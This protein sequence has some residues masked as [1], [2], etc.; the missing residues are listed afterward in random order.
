MM[1]NRMFSSLMMGLSFSVLLTALPARAQTLTVGVESSQYL[2]AY[3]YENGEYTG[4]AR[5]LLDAFA[6]DKGYRL[7]YKALPVVRLFS[8]LLAG[9]I[10]LKFPDNAMWSASQKTGHDVVYSVPVIAYVDGVSVVPASKGMT[11]DAVRSLGLMRGFTAWDWQ[12]RIMAG[13][14]SL[15]ENNSFPALLETTIA[16]RNNGAYA[17]V[18]VVNHQLERVLH[19]PGALVFDPGLPHTRSDYHLSSIKRPDVIAAFNAWMA[20]NTDRVARMKAE[21]QVEKGVE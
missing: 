10:D 18:A 19:K 20:A 12:D 14:V 13:T 21:F 5:V 1:F 17:N 2:P 3:S 8:E 7:E 11:V 9:N 4:F 16:G 6:Q 15:H